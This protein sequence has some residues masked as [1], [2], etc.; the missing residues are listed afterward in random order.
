MTDSST[1]QH[2]NDQGQTNWYTRLDPRVRRV[3]AFLGVL[4]TLVL[5]WEL[6]KVVGKALEII[7]P[8]RPDNVTM[9]HVWDIIFELFQPARRGG[10]MLLVD[11]AQSVTLHAAGSVLG[12]VIGGASGSESASCS[13]GPD[14]PSGL[15]A[16]RRGQ[17]TVPI[18]A[19]APMVVV[20]GGSLAVPATGCRCHIAAYLTFFPVAI[21]TLRGLRS[22]DPTA[23]EL[24]RSMRRPRREC[25]GNCRCRRPCPTS[26]RRSRCRPPPASSGPSSASCRPA[27]LRARPALLDFSQRSRARPEALRTRHRDVVARASLRRAH[28][29]VEHRVVRAARR[30]P[31]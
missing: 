30:Q 3:V 17:Q 15:H 2:I 12:F 13:Y 10:E 31:A 7:R 20:W 8:V 4:A 1:A 16:L 23:I 25:S 6:Y 28:H 11:P 27:S 5:L 24:M 21:N 9:P 18:L 19:I 22:P 14:W 26:S 29:A